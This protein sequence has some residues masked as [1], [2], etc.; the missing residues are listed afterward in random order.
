MGVGKTTEMTAFD[1]ETNV[2]SQ[3]V[4]INAYKIFGHGW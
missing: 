1:L 3:N 2:Y 4:S